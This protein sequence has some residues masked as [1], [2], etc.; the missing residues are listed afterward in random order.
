[1]H[2]KMGEMG[3]HV[4]CDFYNKKKS[5]FSSLI[6]ASAAHQ[7]SLT[8]VMSDGR[9]GDTRA[10]PYHAPTSRPRFQPRAEAPPGS[11]GSCPRS[12]RPPGSRGSSP[13]P[14]H[15]RS[16]GALRTGAAVAGHWGGTRAPP[17]PPEGKGRSAG[18]LGPKEAGCA[19]RDEK[20]QS[21][22]RVARA[23]PTSPR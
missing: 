20:G 18:G 3:K 5:W 17:P 10:S 8:N 22:L 23:P 12:R 16:A 13:S 6:L 7:P 15:P 19:G 2:S 9:S 14:A 21:P 11:A 1:M 4:S